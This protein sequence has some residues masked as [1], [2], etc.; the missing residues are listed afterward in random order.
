[1]TVTNDHTGPTNKANN[2]LDSN[3]MV[4]E[5]SDH[6]NKAHPSKVEH[7]SNKTTTNDKNNTNARCME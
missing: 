1:M 3:T 4:N 5:S 6:T 7:E 2:S